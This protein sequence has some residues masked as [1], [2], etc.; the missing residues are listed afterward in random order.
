MKRL[1]DGR[2][3]GA[4]DNHQ[5]NLRSVAATFKRAIERDKRLA[6]I[7]MRTEVLTCMWNF[8][9]VRKEITDE[10]ASLAYSY[11]KLSDADFNLKIARLS[12]ALYLLD[13][14]Q[15]L[16]VA[17][18]SNPNRTIVALFDVA[19]S[20]VEDILGESYFFKSKERILYDYL[21]AEV[22]LAS[23]AECCSV[24]LLSLHDAVKQYKMK[25]ADMIEEA[26]RRAA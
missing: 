9:T 15:E 25:V 17:V 7:A 10:A 24:R 6:P 8:A 13:K 19:R 11:M 18:R 2:V 26:C 1:F 5:A 21:E 3:A 4:V 23:C 12:L 16:S 14:M 20:R 22:A